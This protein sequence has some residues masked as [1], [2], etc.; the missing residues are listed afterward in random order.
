[1][2]LPMKMEVINRIAALF[3]I[4]MVGTLTG[5]L[6]IVSARFRGDLSSFLA[7]VA[8]PAFLFNSILASSG[9]KNLSSGLAMVGLSL[10]I[11][12]V[13]IVLASL[14]KGIWQVKELKK[15]AYLFSMVFPNMAFLGMPVVEAALGSEGVFYGAFY[16]LIV[17]TLMWT[18]GVYLFRGSQGDFKLR[19]VITPSFVAI[20]LA[21]IFLVLGLELPTMLAL[22]VGLLSATS[23]PLSMIVLGLMLSEMKLSEVVEGPSAILACIY[24]LLIFPLVTFYILRFLGFS[25]Y[26]L[27]VPVIIMAMP[28]A[29]MG[30]VQ[31]S[32]Y[33]RD[34]KSITGLIVLSTLLSLATIPF[35]ISVIM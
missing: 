1:M 18:Y 12:G 19:Q 14:S 32:T 33:G 29:A 24:R 23:A 25:S 28:V 5:K 2:V 30:A 6:K 8:L 16:I 31:A 34:Y 20:I 13:G 4:L 15:P 27:Q 11:Y 7:K 10:A 3:I 26:Y 21:L 9:V 17:D 22:P 35:I